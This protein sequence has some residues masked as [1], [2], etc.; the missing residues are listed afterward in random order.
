MICSVQKAMPTNPTCECRG[1][2]KM[3]YK[4]LSLTFTAG[5]WCLDHTWHSWRTDLIG[6]KGRDHNGHDKKSRFNS[7]CQP[8]SK[9]III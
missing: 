1:N 4:F 5:H 8:E 9:L 2:V 3:L 6:E 7:K